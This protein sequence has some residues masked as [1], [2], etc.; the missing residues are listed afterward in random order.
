MKTA[1][2]IIGL[3]VIFLI[4]VFVF[5]ASAVYQPSQG[6]ALAITN[7]AIRQKGYEPALPEHDTYQAR[8]SSMD[9]MA[10]AAE[11]LKLGQI[12]ENAKVL[13]IPGVDKSVYL[14]SFLDEADK[15]QFLAVMARGDESKKIAAM[16]EKNEQLSDQLGVFVGLPPTQSIVDVIAAARTS[17]AGTSTDILYKLAEQ[18]ESEYDKQPSVQIDAIRKIVNMGPDAMYIVSDDIIRLARDGVPSVQKEA[19]FAIARTEYL[20]AY[21]ILDT[22][23][24]LLENSDSATRANARVAIGNIGVNAISALDARSKTATAELVATIKDIKRRISI[25]APLARTSSSGVLDESLPLHKRLPIIIK[26]LDNE[27]YYLRRNAV[28]AA[29]KIAPAMYPGLDKLIRLLEDE[30]PAIRRYAAYAIKG[31][32]YAA[33]DSLERRLQPGTANKELTENINGIIKSI[34]PGYLEL[35][36]GTPVKGAEDVKE[37]FGSR[38]EV[39]SSSGGIEVNVETITD[40]LAQLQ[41]PELV[42]RQLARE[43]LITISS[44]ANDM[45]D[46]IVAEVKDPDDIEYAKALKAMVQSAIKLGAQI[47]PMDVDLEVY[48]DLSGSFANQRINIDQRNEYELQIRDAKKELQKRKMALNL[49]EH[50]Q[51]AGIKIIPVDEMTQLIRDVSTAELQISALTRKMQIL[52]SSVA[53]TSSSGFEKEIK[54][55][56]APFSNTRDALVNTSTISQ[57]DGSMLLKQIKTYE[58]VIEELEKIRAQSSDAAIAVAKHLNQAQASLN[59]MTT[60]QNMAAEEASLRDVTGTIVINDKDIPDNQKILLTMLDKSNPYLEALQTKLG[61]QVRLLSQ[62][63]AKTDGT[64]HTIAISSMSVDNISRRIDINSI[65]QDGY[66][67]LEQVIVLAKGLLTYSQETK[68]VLYGIIAKMYKFITKAPI[69]P[70]LLEAFLRN[71]VFVLDLPIPLAIDEAYYEQLHRQALAALIAA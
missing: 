61:C 65:T 56:M 16:I 53:K 13:D 70:K 23:I 69:S 2:F 12:P 19:V 15:T 32:G 55:A 22:L 60:V 3:Q 63:N 8:L 45:F 34:G 41:S 52:D 54:A 4:G 38:P 28:I 18:L 59:T 25:E 24:G 48:G 21:E 50:D 29:T 44:D 30:Y 47:Q 57:L 33:V 66:L 35:T 62:Y 14:V 58:N 51:D 10:R 67:P 40:L 64:G 7:L 5:S 37:L 36:V 42:V 46:K 27:D 71:S 26:Q 6:G 1:K 43:N 68:P 31:V 17:S 39:K 49:A 20:N 11:A 9:N